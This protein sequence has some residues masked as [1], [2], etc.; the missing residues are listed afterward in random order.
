MERIFYIVDILRK[1]AWTSPATVGTRNKLQKKRRDRKRTTNYSR[2]ML[3]VVRKST[4]GLCLQNHEVLGQIASSESH[5]G[6]LE[7]RTSILSD[8]SASQYSLDLAEHQFNLRR[9]RPKTP[10]FR[11]GQRED[12]TEQATKA[13]HTALQLAQDYQALLPL[14]QAPH[15][16]SAHPHTP[17]RLRKVK[18]QTSLRDLSRDQA[19]EVASLSDLDGD[20]E[21]LV[22]SEPTSPD[23]NHDPFWTTSS[24]PEKPSCAS[25]KD[26]VNVTCSPDAN[27]DEDVGLQICVDLLTNKLASIL[28]RHHP[29][30]DTDRASELQILLM[31][32]AY[33]TIQKQIHESRTKSPAATKQAQQLELLLENWLDVLYDLYD[34]SQKIKREGMDC[35]QAE[36]WGAPV[37]THPPQPGACT[38]CNG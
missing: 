7:H 5:L 3:E 10:I 29:I 35:I 13:N 37:P 23:A 2:E 30:E 14:H 32:E 19:K 22:G 6:L 17:R 12:P 20:M 16:L 21:T 38:S 28:F 9:T 36:Y 1:M 26:A 24:F 15:L 34:R 31:I 4:L 11:V 27:D 33:E 25:I 18:S 8:T